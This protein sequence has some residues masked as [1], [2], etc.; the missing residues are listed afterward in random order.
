MT[1]IKRSALV[2]YSVRQMFELVDNIEDY[3]RFLPWCH[4]SHV[5]HRDAEEVL[6]TLEIV[7]SGIHKNFTT[8]NHLHPHEKIEMTLVTGPFRHLEGRWRFVALGDRGCKVNMELEFELA[9]GIMDKVFQPIFNHIANS[10]V[11]AF[12]KRAVEVY[13]TP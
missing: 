10:L 11:D 9:G 6:A 1:I 4:Q 12:C 3:P 2:S 5:T 7:W 8:R 13:G